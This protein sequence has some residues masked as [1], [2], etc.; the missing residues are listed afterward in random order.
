[1]TRSYCG[2]DFG[3]SNSTVGIWQNNKASLSALEGSHTTIPTAIFFDYED[4][5]TLFGR[6]AVSTYIEGVEGRLMK[7]LK[8]VLGSSLMDEKAI[9][10]RKSTSFIDIIGFFLNHLKTTTEK[11]TGNELD[12]VVL[13]RPVYFVDNN[14]TADQSAQDALEQAAKD[15]GFRNI[16]FQYE[17]I[18]AALDFE[19][20]VADEK[21]AFI[22][23]IGGGTSDFSIVK[24]SPENRTKPDRREDV[25]ANLGVHVG[26][27]DFD[28]ELDLKKVMPHLGYRSEV[29]NFTKTEKLPAPNDY[30]IS[31]STWNMINTLYKKE[32]VEDI[33]KL[34]R[35]SL[36]PELIK[37]LLYVVTERYGHR[38]LT[39]IEQAKIALSENE[40]TKLTLPYIDETLQ[41]DITK[42]E[43]EETIEKL[44]D[45]ILGTVDKTL[46]Q[47]G[48]TSDKIDVVFLTGGSTSIPY[49]RETILSRFKNADYIKG[50]LFGSV[51]TGLTI[52]AHKAFGN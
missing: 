6:E 52:E 25:L 38:I 34:L 32:R 23:D 7:S 5:D 37:R 10:N 28:R 24:V 42:S 51:G 48:L 27:T 1:M 14:E 4:P 18:A 36:S 3:T 11:Q 9:I 43:F 30:F 49:I 29:W 20:S 15:Q 45:R 31:L 39:D 8:S 47:A 40:N 22:V 17:P 21:L 50:D 13:G 35:F 12:S 26:G 44:K 46:Q 33:R 41:A 2:I 19:Q 16:R